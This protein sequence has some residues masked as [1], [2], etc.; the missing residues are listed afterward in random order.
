[1]NPKARYKQVVET[2]RQNTGGRQPPLISE[3]AARVTAACSAGSLDL[4]HYENALKAAVQNDDLL[5]W[6]DQLAV[7]E[8]DPL[9]AVIEAEVASDSP[10]KALIGR[11]NQL[12]D[13]VDRG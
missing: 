2:V 3:P 6:H 8:P 7:A 11:C 4:D 9:Q 12:L 13:E 1:M 5:R 10:R